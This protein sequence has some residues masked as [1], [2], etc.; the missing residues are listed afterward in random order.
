MRRFLVI[1]LLLVELDVPVA[2]IENINSDF[3]TARTSRRIG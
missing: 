1:L 3:A 2:L